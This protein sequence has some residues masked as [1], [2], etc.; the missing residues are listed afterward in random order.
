MAIVEHRVTEV[1]GKQIMKKIVAGWSWATNYD[2]NGKGRIWVIWDPNII[3]FSEMW[4]SNQLIHGKVTIGVGSIQFYFTTVYG[5][6]TIEDRKILWH[7]LEGIHNGTDEAWI[8]MGDY[9][10]ILGVEDR[11]SDNP[12]QEVEIRDF[13]DF[14]LNNNMNELKY[15][16]RKYIWTNSHVWS[17]IDRA[18]VNTEWMTTMKQM[19]VI[20]MDRFISDFTPLSIHFDE[21]GQGGPKP[22]RF[23]NYVA[24]NSEFLKVV[25]KA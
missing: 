18:I 5:L 10:A 23:Y 4:K 1:K 3:Q 15:I 19:E 8:A 9:N 25:E 14:M 16:G 20:V 24:E 12:V 11:E 21:T 7:E 13:S 22:Y 6:H 17:K 2:E